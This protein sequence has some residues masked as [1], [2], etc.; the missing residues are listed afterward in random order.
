M[1]F[2]AKPRNLSRQLAV[3]APFTQSGLALLRDGLASRQ[4]FEIPHY[5]R[6]DSRGVGDMNTYFCEQA[7]INGHCLESRLVGRR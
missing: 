3:A 1:S 5:V 6:N 2:R 7:L 4:G